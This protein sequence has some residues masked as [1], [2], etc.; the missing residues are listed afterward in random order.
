[1]GIL[2]NDSIFLVFKACRTDY[3]CS[4]RLLNFMGVLRSL[5]DPSFLDCLDKVSMSVSS[6]SNS[7]SRQRILGWLLS[8]HRPKSH[9]FR[10]LIP[11]HYCQIVPPSIICF[12]QV[13]NP[14]YR[15][16]IT[17]YKYMF[18]TQSKQTQ[19]CK[20]LR[21]GVTK[22]IEAADNSN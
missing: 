18:N 20:C 13:K 4:A 17:M 12:R 5:E 11:Y 6:Q 7:L 2:I 21:S 3:P 19:Y 1:M 10:S 9:I 8:L 14:D 15:Q 22:Q 16:P